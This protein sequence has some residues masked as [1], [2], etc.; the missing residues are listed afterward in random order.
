MNIK[1]FDKKS[2]DGSWVRVMTDD[3]DP[4]YVGLFKS[5]ACESL[6]S[7]EFALD[8]HWSH[9]TRIPK[10]KLLDFINDKL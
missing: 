8:I 2:W 1:Y 6:P 5:R 10:Q 4:K 7:D 9:G 3:N